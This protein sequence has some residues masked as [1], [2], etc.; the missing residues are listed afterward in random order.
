MVGW[1][2]HRE[3]SNKEVLNLL[4]LK[5]ANSAAHFKRLEPTFHLLL[6][7]DT[8]LLRYKL[9]IW[10]FLSNEWSFNWNSFPYR[11]PNYAG[12]MYP[13]IVHTTDC[14]TNNR[15]S[16]QCHLHYKLSVFVPALVIV[17]LRTSSLS[18]HDNLKE[19]EYWCALSSISNSQRNF[20][21]FETSN[22]PL[23]SLRPCLQLKGTP[24]TTWRHLMP[25]LS[26]K[27][28]KCIL[29]KYI[30]F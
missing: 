1:V 18:S 23:T 2:R 6:C 14:K 30:T 24:H 16:Q 22:R 27:I 7:L 13:D 21:I 5:S 29:S 26:V 28:Q 25:G 8:A 3:E 19:P 10:L 17:K 15:N 20:D 11:I 4:I 9:R 12:N